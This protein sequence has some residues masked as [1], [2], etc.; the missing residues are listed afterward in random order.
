MSLVLLLPISIGGIGLRDVTLV[1]MLGGFG[2]ATDQA[3]AL[4]LALLGLQLAM[5]VVGA[6]LML[7]PTS[8]EV[9]PEHP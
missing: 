7:L 8:K 2:I 3:L 1:G 4:S 6:I 9:E 5:V